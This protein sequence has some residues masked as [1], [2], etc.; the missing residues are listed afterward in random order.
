MLST[1]DI[2]LQIL[3]DAKNDGNGL[4]KYFHIQHPS[5]RIAQEDNNIFVACVSSEN[6]IEGF[7]HSTFKDLVEVLIVTKQLEYEKAV[8]IIKNVS[9]EICRLIME[10]SNKFPNKPVIRNINPEFNK[11]YVLTRGHIMIQV[12]TAPIDFNVSDEDYKICSII[13][14]GNA[15]ED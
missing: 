4:L 12:N 15:V 8:L 3:R 2:I 14:N 9:F 7:E 10:N 1:D 6:N 5:N 11:D 13:L